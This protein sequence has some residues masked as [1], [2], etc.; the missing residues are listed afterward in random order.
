MEPLFNERSLL[1]NIVMNMDIE[2]L[3]QLSQTNHIIQNFLN[4]K[5]TMTAL[6]QKYLG[7]LDYTEVYTFNDLVWDVMIEKI[8]FEH[9]NQYL[10]EEVIRAVTAKGA[11]STAVINNR[12]LNSGDKITNCDYEYDYEQEY[13]SWICQAAMFLKSHGFK[14]EIFNDVDGIDDRKEINKIY[15][16][17]LKLLK[18]KALNFYLTNNTLLIN[19]FTTYKTGRLN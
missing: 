1:F 9:P 4:E 18:T 8:G 5:Y 13:T 19:P 3:Y 15:M 17:W 11:S 7:Y 6:S 10:K 16:A 12:F 2:D 14:L